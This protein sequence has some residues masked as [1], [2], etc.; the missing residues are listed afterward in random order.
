MTRQPGDMCPHCGQTSEVDLGRAP[1]HQCDPAMPLPAPATQHG[2]C[3]PLAGKFILWA[4][5]TPAR[6][7][8]I[9][10]RFT[11]SQSGTLSSPTQALWATYVREVQG[12]CDITPPDAT[13]W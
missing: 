3:R 8:S 11:D 4:S 5:C 9:P 7:V 1:T 2:A 6:A 12:A 10:T 13:D